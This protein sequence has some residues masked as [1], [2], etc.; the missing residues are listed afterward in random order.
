[1]DEPADRGQESAEPERRSRRRDTT[2]RPF[3]RRLPRA[4]RE[5]RSRGSDTTRR[6]FGRRP[7]PAEPESE[8]RGGDTQERNDPRLLWDRSPPAEPAEPAG[9]K[10][11]SRWRDAI[12][13]SLGLPSPDAPAAP[14]EPEPRARRS[15]ADKS[16]QLRMVWDG[17]TDEIKGVRVRKWDPDGWTYTSV[18][19]TEKL[20]EDVR[21]AFAHFLAEDVVA[22]VW[23]VP[24]TGLGS[25]ANS[26]EVL[27]A[28]EDLLDPRLLAAEMVRIIVQAAAAHAGI[29]LPVA[30]VMGQAAADLFIELL[31]PDP[32]ADKVQA[33]QYADLTLSAEKGSAIDSPALPQIAV[34]E[35]ADV[36]DK[37][38]SPDDPPPARPAERRPRPG[39]VT[40]ARPAEHRPD[41]DG[42]GLG[43]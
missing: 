39:D 10:S 20:A 40:P 37:L 23:H 36:I 7:P 27:T 13:D 31:G 15:P 2:R 5:S 24:S 22:A 34:S 12:G 29:P 11:R 8:S 4:S 25:L 18:R 42:F 28:A 9:P 1:M 38:L 43:V 33:V 17:R 41:D 6:P 21:R 35:A 3:G 14:A 32:D 19:P 26:A 30:R 16:V